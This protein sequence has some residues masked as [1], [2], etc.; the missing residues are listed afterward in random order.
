MHGLMSNEPSIKVKK[1]TKCF[2]DNINNKHIFIT[3][4]KKFVLLS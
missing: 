3:K 2:D 4:K 1:N